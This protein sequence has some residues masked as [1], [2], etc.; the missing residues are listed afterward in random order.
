MGVENAHHVSE[1]IE[2]SHSLIG[3]ITCLLHSVEVQPVEIGRFQV[4]MQLLQSTTRERACELGEL[5]RL[6]ETVFRPHLPQ[7]LDVDLMVWTFFH[8]PNLTSRMILHNTAEC[9]V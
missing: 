9:C 3:P 2:R 4:R 8:D 5:E 1:S 6:S 7:N